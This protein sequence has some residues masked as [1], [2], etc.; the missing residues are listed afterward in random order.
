MSNKIAKSLFVIKDDLAEL[1]EMYSVLV[2]VYPEIGRAIRD[3][4]DSDSPG[5]SKRIL[6]Y[7][8]VDEYDVEVK[9]TFKSVKKHK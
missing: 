2:S 8:L 9:K 3:M 6:K 4:P 7:K 5:A 1:G